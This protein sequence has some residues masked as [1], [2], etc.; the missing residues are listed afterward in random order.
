MVDLYSLSSSGSLHRLLANIEALSLNIALGA[1]YSG[2]Y[3]L[4]I[5][6]RHPFVVIDFIAYS[7]INLLNTS[8]NTKIYLCPKFD[9]GI[10]PCVSTAI[11]SFGLFL[12]MSWGSISYFTFMGLA[13]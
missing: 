8:Y 12:S 9:V 6:L 5:L 4:V 1:P 13:F 2:I 11:N 10:G 3:F 7:V